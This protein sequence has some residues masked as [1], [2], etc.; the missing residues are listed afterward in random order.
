MSINI[1]NVKR[2]CKD[3]ISKIENYDKAIADN[4]NVWVCHHRLE[5]T[6]DNEFAHTKDDLIRMDMYYKRPY[7]ELIFM[8]KS[9][10]LKLHGRVYGS[11]M[12]GKC[13]SEDTKRKIKEAR[14]NIS[15]ESRKKMSDAAIGRYHSEVTK[16][17]ISEAQKGKKRAPF[18][19]EHKRKM[20]E[21]MKKYWSVRKGGKNR[22]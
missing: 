16:K 11:P 10:H 6:L 7:F 4:T 5:L 1:K 15:D 22:V 13:H 8:T 9:E 2:F 19:G 14:K 17:K 21:S 3:D 12:K 18:S 20:S